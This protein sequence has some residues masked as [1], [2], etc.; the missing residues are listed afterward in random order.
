MN[1]HWRHVI[2]AEPDKGPPWTLKLVDGRGFVAI[3]TRK[4]EAGEYVLTE[5]PTVWVHGWHPFDSD[6]VE[7][8]ESRVEALDE[9]DKTAFYSMANVFPEARTAA[10]GIFMTNCFDMTDSPH[11]QA[12]AMYLA[13]ARLNHS[14]IP[15][16]QQTHIPETGEEVL[17]A[18]RTI[19]I[20]DEINDCY[21][22]LRQS[23][24]ARRA[25]L[26]DIYRFD[27]ECEACGP[28]AP[29]LALV[30][31]SSILGHNQTQTQQAIVNICSDSPAAV[32]KGIHSVFLQ[33]SS[34]L[35]PSQLL[36]SSIVDCSSPNGSE[37]ACWNTPSTNGDEGD[38]FIN[39]KED[40]A[41][42][43]RAANFEDLILSCVS[44]EQGNSWIN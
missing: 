29:A 14:C 34:T 7:E 16:V 42:R 31:Q 17:Y 20:G 38:K 30:D 1:T 36:P 9:N 5:F 28:L 27:C 41:Y 4:I 3:A 26:R 6:Q 12:C 22:D 18:S 33:T 21:I 19:E 43:I 23:R 32:K 13:L 40:D 39:V 2:F 8:I 10:E 37:S 35:A 11:G 25:A 24:D 44:S 15:N